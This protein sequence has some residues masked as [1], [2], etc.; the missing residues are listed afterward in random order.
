M[1]YTFLVEELLTQPSGIVTLVGLEFEILLF[2]TE[3]IKLLE[4]VEPDTPIE[5][6]DLLGDLGGSVVF[7]PALS[8]QR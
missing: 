8:C 2:D 6:N 5:F 4:D 3:D 1:K 7:L